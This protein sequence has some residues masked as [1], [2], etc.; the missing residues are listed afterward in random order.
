M[1]SLIGSRVAGV[2]YTNDTGR[3]FELNITIDPNL[4]LK[5]LIVD[6]VVVAQHEGIN[7]KSERQNLSAIIPAGSLYQL[8]G[9]AD[10]LSIWTETR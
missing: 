1:V 2:N 10:L 9:S 5:S 6:G 8:D 4:V 7:T 3:S